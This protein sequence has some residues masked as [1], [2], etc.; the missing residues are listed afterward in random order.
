MRKAM[1]VLVIALL[2]GQAMAAC[3]YPDDT[4]ADGSRCGGRAASERPGGR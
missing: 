3:D 1:M 4:A 2:A